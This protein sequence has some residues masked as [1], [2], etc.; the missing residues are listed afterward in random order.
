MEIKRKRKGKSC[1]YFCPIVADEDV[2]ALVHF[3]LD[4]VTEEVWKQVMTATYES[5]N[6]MS[7]TDQGHERDSLV[8]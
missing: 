5:S 3:I 8:S 4:K 2:T 1:P 7:S 6:I